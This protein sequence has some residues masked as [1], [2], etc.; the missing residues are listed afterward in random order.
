MTYHPVRE[1]PAQPRLLKQARKG[2]FEERLRSPFTSLSATDH[3]QCG[4]ILRR[5]NS[6]LRKRGVRISIPSQR[7]DAF[8]AGDGR[9]CFYQGAAD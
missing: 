1:R 3:S 6:D 5:M 8:G 4:Y 9:R 2:L 7:M